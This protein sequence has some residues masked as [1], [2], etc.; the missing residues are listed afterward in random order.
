MVAAGIDT[1]VCLQ[2]EY[3]EYGCDVYPETLRRGPPPPHELRF[4]HCPIPDFG[5]LEDESLQALV[6]EL[7][8]ELADGHT[9]YIHCMGGHGRTGTVVANLLM[10]T[11]DLN[12]RAAMRTLQLAHRGRGCHGHCALNCGELEDE[13]QTTQSQKMQGVMKRQHKIGGGGGG[14]G[15]GG[16]GSGGGGGGWKKK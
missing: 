1:F 13:S 16:G 11:N 5:V 12:F 7:Q 3:T 9:L 6:A 8:R 15:D 4:V 2:T 10:A 14:G